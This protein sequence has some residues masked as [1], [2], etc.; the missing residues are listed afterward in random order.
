MRR[1]RIRIAY[2]GAGFQ[3]W[4]SQQGRGAI[5]DLVE[6]AIAS[7]T[8]Q[9]VRI[10]SAG[11]TDAGVHALGQEAHFDLPS[12]IRIPCEKWPEA[13][14]TKLPPQIRVMRCHVVSPTFHARFSAVAKT[15]R[16]EIRLGRILPPHEY[17]RVW[18]VP[19]PLDIHL[20]YKGLAAFRGRHDFRSFAANRG[21]LEPDTV[22]EIFQATAVARGKRLSIIFKGDGFLYRMVRLMVGGLVQMA[23]GRMTFDGMTQLIDPPTDFKAK[24]T[25]CAPACG[26]TLVRVFYSNTKSPAA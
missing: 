12:N 24:C 23:A 20:L 13:L 22:R 26:L 19:M 11:R 18:L 16:Y 8:G 25:F 9:R 4:Q 21:S 7:L 3:G 2:D 17:N 6:D 15:Y 14:N 1:L 10:H 5:Q